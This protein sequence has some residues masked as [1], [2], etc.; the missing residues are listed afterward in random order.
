MTFLLIFLTVALS[1]ISNDQ[2]QDSTWSNLS[3]ELWP[4]LEVSKDQL[5]TANTKNC[6]LENELNQLTSK[7]NAVNQSLAMALARPATSNPLG[8][9]PQA[10]KLSK[11]FADPRTYDRSRGKKFKEWWTHILT[12]QDKNSATLTGTASICAVLSR[13]VE[14]TNKASQ[15][16]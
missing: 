15:L 9:A 10:S 6:Q 12:W 3:I 2:D 1:T 8:M 5:D 4:Y 7:L 16:P 13:M 11:I 14:T